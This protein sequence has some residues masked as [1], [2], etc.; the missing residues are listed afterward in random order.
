MKTKILTLLF[1]LAFV[2][3]ANADDQGIIKVTEEPITSDVVYTIP[4]YGNINVYFQSYPHYPNAPHA[5]NVGLND[6]EELTNQQEQLNDTDA[7]ITSE[8]YEKRPPEV[9]K[10]YTV[11]T[12]TSDALKELTATDSTIFWVYDEQHYEVIIHLKFNRLTQD[13]MGQLIKSMSQ[14]IDKACEFDIK[15]REVE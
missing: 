5:G 2:C 1:L 15:F 9:P 4:S 3:V 6:D 13:M 8:G 10:S 11:V 12:T 14:Q 7:T